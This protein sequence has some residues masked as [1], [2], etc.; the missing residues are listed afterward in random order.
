MAIITFE[1]TD[2]RSIVTLKFDSHMSVI[3]KLVIKGFPDNMEKIVA[4]D[5]FASV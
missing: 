1:I 3:P 4:T 2:N 5:F